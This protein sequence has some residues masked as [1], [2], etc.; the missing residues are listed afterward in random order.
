MYLYLLL[1]VSEAFKVW[2]KLFETPFNAHRIQKIN[3][4]AANLC[5]HKPVAQASCPSQSPGHPLAS[6][7]ELT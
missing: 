5:L 7:A 4:G 6:T 2:L 3:F 1:F